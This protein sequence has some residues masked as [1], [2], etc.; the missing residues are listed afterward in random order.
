M[1]VFIET[2]GVTFQS[3]GLNVVQADWSPSDWLEND[4]NP[5]YSNA[6]GSAMSSFNYYLNFNIDDTILPANATIGVDVYYFDTIGGIETLVDDAGLTYDTSSFPLQ[7]DT[8]VNNWGVG[9]VLNAQGL[10]G[11]NTTPEPS[12]LFLIGGGLLALGGKTLKRKLSP[13]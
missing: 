1:E 2:P 12:T 13:R 9:A 3:P 11:E 7:F 6:S 8:S 4:V 10:A 5:G